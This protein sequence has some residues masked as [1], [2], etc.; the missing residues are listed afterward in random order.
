MTYDPV[1]PHNIFCGANTNV[2]QTKTNTEHKQ[3]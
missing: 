2:N 3:Q 1:F